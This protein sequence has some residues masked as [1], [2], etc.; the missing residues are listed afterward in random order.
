MRMLNVSIITFLC[1][2]VVFVCI[3][4]GSLCD[5]SWN[6]ILSL[7]ISK[8]FK[9]NPNRDHKKDLQIQG[10]VMKLLLHVM[11][12]N[13]LLYLTLLLQNNIQKPQ[14]DQLFMN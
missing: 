3:C 1:C 13:F 11:V 9:P 4:L 14:I 10:N 12:Y 5:G 7:R 8:S 6:L 2:I